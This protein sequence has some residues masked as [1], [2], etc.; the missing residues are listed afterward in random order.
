M[1]KES[2]DKLMNDLENQWQ[3]QVDDI[4]ESENRA[5]IY[6]IELEFYESK[7]LDMGYSEDQI[8]TVLQHMGY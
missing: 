1:K 8:E 6:D 7:C 4:I 5:Y 2:L 3:E